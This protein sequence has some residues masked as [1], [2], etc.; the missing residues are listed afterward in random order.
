MT[1]PDDLRARAIAL[2]DRFTHEAGDRRA[3]MRDMAL[4]A[5]SAVAAETLL[6]GIAADPAHAAIVPAAD[7]RLKIQEV[8]WAG[9]NKRRMRGY[10]ARPAGRAVRRGAVLVIHENR[11]LTEHI[12][13]IAR[14]VALAGFVAVAAD[15]LSPNGGTVFPG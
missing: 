14:R 11:G 9:S 4:L 1:Q 12:R 13:D 3:F 6:L 10:Q 7:P 15:F 2:Y 8:S 5:G